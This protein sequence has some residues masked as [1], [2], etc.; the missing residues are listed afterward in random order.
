MSDPNNMV[1]QML[2]ISVMQRQPNQSQSQR[3]QKHKFK[4]K[5]RQSSDRLRRR[6][7][8]CLFLTAIVPSTSWSTQ[9]PTRMCQLNGVIV[10]RKRSKMERRCNYGVSAPATTRSIPWS[11][12]VWLIESQNINSEELWVFMLL[13]RGLLC[14]GIRHCNDNDSSNIKPSFY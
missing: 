3:R 6:S 7:H 9:M 2:T 13:L 10:M 11:V 12:T 8:S 5:S 1:G 4:K 14:Y